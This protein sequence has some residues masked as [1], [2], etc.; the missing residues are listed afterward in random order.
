MQSTAVLQNGGRRIRW[1][2]RRRNK[3]HDSAIKLLAAA[4]AA[5]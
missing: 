2:A 4:L 5:C 3:S 1:Q